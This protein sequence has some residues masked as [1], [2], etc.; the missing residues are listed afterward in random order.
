MKNLNSNN[1][2]RGCLEVSMLREFQRNTA[3]MTLLTQALQNPATNNFEH[4]LVEF[5]LTSIDTTVIGTVQDSARL[6]GTHSPR[7]QLG[8]IAK[9]RVMLS[10]QIRHDLFE[11]YN[12]QQARVHYPS[13]QGSS[14][15]FPLGLHADFY[16]FIHLDGRRI[17]A[18][19][20]AM[21][22]NEGSSLIQTEYRN[23]SFVGRVHEIFIHKQSGLQNAATTPLAVV[24][25]MVVSKNTP[26]DNDEF[27]WNDF[28]ELSVES[29]E[30]RYAQ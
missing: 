14:K 8:T 13:E 26:L 18:S 5:L 19:S 24:D 21:H 10:D 2:T 15:T 29:W 30:I 17:V 12:S 23:E 28:P 1:W 9:Q 25:W 7:I 16:K 4:R 20:Q 22:N 27:P 3:V 6:S 11:H